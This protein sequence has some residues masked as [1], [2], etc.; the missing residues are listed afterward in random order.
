MRAAPPR[1]SMPNAPNASATEGS[2]PVSPRL[3]A[4]TLACEQCGAETAHRIVRWTRG[5]SGRL[6]RS[7][8]ARCRV[9]GFTHPFDLP[10]PRTVSLDRIDS[11]GG[12]SRR[13][14]IALD[15]STSLE[16][17]APF[18]GS[19]PPVR[20]RRLDLRQ[21]RS[22][23]SAP[24]AAVATVW[25]VPVGPPRVKVSVRSG[26]RT[27]AT[28]WVA[29]E[30][31]RIGVGDSVEVDGRTA[32]VVALRAFGRTWRKP[33]DR[34]AAEEVQRLYARRTVSPPAGR[35]DWS[36]VRERPSSRASSTS[37]SSRSRSGPGVRR[38]RTV[39]RARTAAGGATVHSVS[40]L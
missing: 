25:T 14:R 12:E 11:S 16:V 3:L 38:N 4:A 34:F 9:C 1:G 29:P 35:A 30:G 26:A 6:P 24:A 33:G 8:L 20:V 23:K 10:V 40:P 37:R 5:P 39:P 2:R 27:D 15:A 28:T 7:G 19:D 36:Q 31:T 17:G 18:P 13:E 21:G 22:A 32:E